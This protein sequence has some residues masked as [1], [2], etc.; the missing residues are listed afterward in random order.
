MDPWNYSLLNGLL[1]FRSPSF[2]CYLASQIVKR[3]VHFSRDVLG[4]TN[5]S[6]VLI[7]LGIEVLHLLGLKVLLLD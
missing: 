2:I 3:N 5:S 1:H 4:P 7:N 6:G